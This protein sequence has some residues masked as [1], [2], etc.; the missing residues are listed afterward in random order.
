MEGQPTL[1]PTPCAPSKV[2]ERLRRKP[3]FQRQPRETKGK[4][5]KA[6]TRV[7]QGSCQRFV[8]VPNRDGMK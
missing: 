6:G 1:T 2:S 5:A 8:D 7:G 4:Y 3:A